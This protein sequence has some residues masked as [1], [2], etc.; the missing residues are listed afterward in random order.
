[1]F[2][3]SFIALSVM[4]VFLSCR[5]T[6]E[7]T[8]AYCSSLIDSSE[9]AYR[10][11]DLRKSI[12]YLIKAR[13]ISKEKGYDKLYFETLNRLAR[14]FN[15]LDDYDEA[16]ALVTTSLTFAE[17]ELNEI[18]EMSA[19]NN[20]GILMTNHGDL[21]NAKQV[22]HENFRRAKEMNESIS[23]GCAASNLSH[24]ARLE[25]K[26]DSSLFYANLALTCFPKS[27]VSFRTDAA[28]GIVYYYV[29]K[30]IKPEAYQLIDSMLSVVNPQR[31]M[32]IYNDLICQQVRLYIADN[33]FNDAL[34]TISQIDVLNQ[35]LSSRK[36][37]FGYY[38]DIYAGLGNSKRALEYKESVIAIM[39]SLNRLKSVLVQQHSQVKFDYLAAEADLQQKN[40]TVMYGSIVVVLLIVTI[41]VV[42]VLVRMKFKR[43][44]QRQ[45]L[46][47]KEKKIVELELQMAADNQNRLESELETSN[48]ELTANVLH[49]STRN[50]LIQETLDYLSTLPGKN[51]HSQYIDKLK[52]Q[53]RND[54][55]MEDFLKYFEKV[56][57]RFLSELHKRHSNLTA[58]DVRFI[59][60]VYM[61]LSNKEIASLL[62]ITVEA[63][64]KRKQRI[65]KK[66][67]IEDFDSLYSYISTL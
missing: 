14:N 28:M 27:S 2:I 25:N 51:G 47:E 57:T 44:R 38:S 54:T 42:G 22:F 10:N 43:N 64:R 8:E 52:A 13:A 33:K 67:N 55:E 24:I 1:M 65:C 16:L 37:T 26:A 30:H 21:E 35:D 29:D 34:K 58:N 7:Q 3:V 56:N 63:V 48:R 11:D 31:D 59:A 66:M 46:V 50:S 41:V 18:S 15:A 39:D 6:Q 53:L 62:N 23:M 4:N 19:S 20:L 49:L 40:I 32:I 61:Q 12:N 60:Y 5:D 45:L 9:M 36:R 17:N